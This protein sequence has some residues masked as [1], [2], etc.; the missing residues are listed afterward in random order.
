MN[1]T[2]KGPFDVK[3]T[4]QP[5]SESG[6]DHS[7]GRFMLDKQYH[8]DLEAKA[9]G[10]MLSAGNGAKGSSGVYVAIE[11]VTGT[12]Q[13]RTGSFILHHTGIMTKGVPEM[14][15]KV[16][17]DSGTGDLAGLAGSMTIDIQ[18]GKHFYG[19]DYTLATVQ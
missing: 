15:I 14:A 17:P 6:T 3:M 8:G 2:A 5:W 19:F 7:L 12:L 4:P 18:E 1:I 16:V 11:K 13:G 10:Q 9:E